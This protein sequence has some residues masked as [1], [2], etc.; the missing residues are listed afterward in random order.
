MPAL[1]APAH[2]LHPP[3]QARVQAEQRADEAKQRLSEAEVELA[4]LRTAHP[5][6]PKDNHP[7]FPDLAKAPRQPVTGEPT[8]CP[9][10][11][12]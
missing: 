5:A 6:A 1:A 3:H 7:G 9:P 10:T 11:T 2:V 8:P 4:R 12:T